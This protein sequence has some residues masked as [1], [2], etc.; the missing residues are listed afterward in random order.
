MSPQSA[1]PSRIQVGTGNGTLNYRVQQPRG[2]ARI[3]NHHIQGHSPPG[4]RQPGITL[5]NPRA[6]FMALE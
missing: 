3:R 4:S 1:N 5:Q 6:N 2:S